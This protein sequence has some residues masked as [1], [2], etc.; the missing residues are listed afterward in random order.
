[1]LPKSHR[2]HLALWRLLHQNDA[3]Q[4]ARRSD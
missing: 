4:D 3:V 1:L 2:F